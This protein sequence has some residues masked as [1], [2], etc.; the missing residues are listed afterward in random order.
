[1]FLRPRQGRPRP[2]PRGV[3]NSR[4]RPSWGWM[5]TAAE[6]L[7]RSSSAIAMPAL[8]ERAAARDFESECERLR[9]LGEAYVLRQFSGML[10]RADAEDAVAEVIV[11]IHRQAAAGRPPRNL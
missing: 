10:G 9:P 3:S 11:R 7:H 8:K 5:A 6:Q 1:L 2:C 4:C